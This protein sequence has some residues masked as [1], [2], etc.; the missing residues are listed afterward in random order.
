MLTIFQSYTLS[1]LHSSNIALFQPYTLSTL[2]SSN[3]TLQQY[4]TPLIHTPPILH[5]SNITLS[6]L[7]TNKV[8]TRDPI[9]SKNIFALSSPAPPGVEMGTLVQGAVTATI[10]MLLTTN[11]GENVVNR[12]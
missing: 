7:T 6:N 9:G 11:D 10:L 8:D 4:Y 1:I 2:H 5:S 3:L 12:S